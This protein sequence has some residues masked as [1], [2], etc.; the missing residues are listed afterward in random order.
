MFLQNV[1]K[2]PA[3]IFCEKFPDSSAA[4]AAEHFPALIVNRTFT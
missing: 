2:F 3:K 1:G 4:G